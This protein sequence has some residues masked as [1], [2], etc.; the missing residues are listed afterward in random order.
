MDV[1][2]YDI[3]FKWDNLKKELLKLVRFKIFAEKIIS[4]ILKIF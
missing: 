2:W 3:F 1:T 4:C